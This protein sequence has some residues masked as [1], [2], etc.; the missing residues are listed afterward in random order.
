MLARVRDLVDF[1]DLAVSGTGSPLRLREREELVAI[2]GGRSCVLLRAAPL[3][4]RF[5]A[6]VPL[7]ADPKLARGS[8]METVRSLGECGGWGSAR[9]I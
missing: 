4:P 5:R 9:G 7:A 1:A 2:A 8:S 6:V 3:G